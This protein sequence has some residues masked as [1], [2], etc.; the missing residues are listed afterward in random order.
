MTMNI[1]SVTAPANVEL[2]AKASSSLEAGSKGEGA[3][4]ADLLSKES[5]SQ[6]T[7]QALPAKDAPAQAAPSQ[8]E[9]S[10]L[11]NSNLEKD[12]AEN[13]SVENADVKNTGVNNTDI[14]NGDIENSKTKNE[15]AIADS[16]APVAERANESATKVANAALKDSAS[17]LDTVDEEADPA[18]SVTTEPAA[19]HSTVP[20][21]AVV[22]PQKIEPNVSQEESD[23]SALT[24]ERLAKDEQKLAPK[25]QVDAEETEKAASKSQ[26]NID[27]T[28]KVRLNSGDNNSAAEQSTAPKAVDSTLE[29]VTPKSAQQDATAELKAGEAKRSSQGGTSLPPSFTP[30]TAE[31]KISGSSN[32]PQSTAAQLATSQRTSVESGSDL[33]AQQGLNDEQAARLSSA[34]K[35]SELGSQ[36]L[37]QRQGVTPQPPAN[38]KEQAAQV[39]LAQNDIE[40]ELQV[41]EKLAKPGSRAPEALTNAAP[42]WLAQIEHGRRWSQDADKPKVSASS[43]KT[44]AANVHL[45]PLTTEQIKSEQVAAR[46][47]FIA[48]PVGDE[49]TAEQSTDTLD[50]LKAEVNPALMQREQPL[51]AP[52]PE[53]TAMLDKALNLHS[54]AEQNAKQLTQQAQVVVSQNLQEAEIKLNP[55]EFGAMRIQIRMEQGEVQVQFVASHPAAREALEQAMP[56]LREMLQQQGMN[57]NQGNQQQTGQQ[58]SNQQHNNQSGGQSSTPFQGSAQ[59][60]AGQQSAEQQPQSSAGEANAS[61]WR[62]YSPSGDEVQEQVSNLR[63]RAPLDSTAAKIDF[64]A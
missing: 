30:L 51:L 21:L 61:Q 9:S 33:N 60:Q 25:T 57:L 34:E 48:S 26:V 13:N 58:H 12:S 44:D 38:A 18:V 47:A 28:A 6:A 41:A 20:T 43:V 14:K 46:A 50:N 52:T 35:R 5:S 59:G 24:A 49:S 37:E 17:A 1:L 7:H 42:E 40:I 29:Q 8:L 55:S 45:P 23:S 4:F 39:L 19:S 11:E 31:Q 53:R 3:A 62:S 2:T 16:D 63:S 27:D 32:E 15:A 36:A 64:F 54:S 10:N 22:S 56:R